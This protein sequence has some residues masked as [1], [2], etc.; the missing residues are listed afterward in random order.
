M[1]REIIRA[2]ADAAGRLQQ[3]GFDGCEVMASHGHLIDHSGPPMPIAVP[4]SMEASWRINCASV[5]RSCRPSAS[6]WEETSSSA[7]A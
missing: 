5:S 3:G 2:F 1:M 4:T 6:E 7:S